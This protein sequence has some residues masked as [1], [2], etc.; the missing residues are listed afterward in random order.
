MYF[1]YDYDLPFYRILFIFKFIFLWSTLLFKKFLYNQNVSFKS[2]KISYLPLF[3]FLQSPINSD[4]HF[5]QWLVNLSF[6][7]M[8]PPQMLIIIKLNLCSEHPL[9]DLAKTIF[10]SDFHLWLARLSFCLLF[11]LHFSPFPLLRLTL[12]KIEM[13]A[14]VVYTKCD[15]PSE[16]LLPVFD[17]LSFTHRPSKREMYKNENKILVSSSFG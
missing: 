1:G 6:E 3:P 15:C 16:I 7:R 5:Q 9:F 13:S 17:F 14:Q 10:F 8:N 2:L 4:F 11:A 12:W